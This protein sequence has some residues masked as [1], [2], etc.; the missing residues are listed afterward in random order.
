MSDFSTLEVTAGSET[1]HDGAVRME[2]KGKKQKNWGPVQASRKSARVDITQNMVERA[3]LL[4]MKQNLK[5]PTMK[6]IAS[7]KPFHVLPVEEI[8]DMTHTV[9]VEIRENLIDRDKNG[10]RDMEDKS[11]MNGSSLVTNRDENVDVLTGRGSLSVNIDGA[12][13]P[14]SL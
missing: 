4:K 9:G 10:S 13:T 1:E 3:K 7:S 5:V 11:A 8:V 14:V 12:S 6:G 2:I